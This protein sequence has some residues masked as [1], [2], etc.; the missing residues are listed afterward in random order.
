MKIPLLDLQAQFAGISDELEA[1]VL[2]VLRGTRYIGGAKV[3]ALEEQLAD[4]AGSRHALGVSSGTDALLISLMALEVGVDD[5]VLT[6]PY[7]FFATAGVVARLGA[8]PVFVDIDPR[9]Y[10]IDSHALVDWLEAHPDEVARVKAIL[11]VHLYGQ[12]ADLDPILEAADRHGIPVVEDAAQAIGARYPSGAGERR[13]GS[14]GA[15]GCF[16]FFPSK[17]LGGIGDGGIVVTDDDA[18]CQKLASLRDHGA[19]PKYFHAL[20][21]GNFRL[22]AIQAAV[23]LAKLPHLERWN[24]ERRANAAYYDEGFAAL[25]VVTP[26]ITWKRDCHV[27]NQYVI[28]VPGRRDEFRAFLAERE[29]GHEVYYPVPLHLQECFAKLGYSKGDL[30]NSEAAAEQTVALPIYPELGREMQA[31]VIAAVRDFYA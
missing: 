25:E 18:L 15:T 17:N 23:L 29:I 24:A 8:R 11:P 5:L 6:T 31:E 14:M 20:V 9:S 2:E 28:R 27:Y 3:E 12:C 22:D 7:S 30:P 19:S 21:G 4:Y 13:A 16:S 10:N 26:S 1:A